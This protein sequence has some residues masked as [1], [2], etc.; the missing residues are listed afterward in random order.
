MVIS[1]IGVMAATT[2]V[3]QAGAGLIASAL[4][5]FVVGLLSLLTVSLNEDH[6]IDT[7]THI[8]LQIF[9]VVFSFK[10]AK[11]LKTQENDSLDGRRIAAL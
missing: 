9:T 5:I 3:D 7:D 8:P 6:F 2:A 1:V 11:L 10:L 4:I